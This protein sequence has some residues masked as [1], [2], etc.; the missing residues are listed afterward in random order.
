MAWRA[1]TMPLAEWGPFQNAFEEIFVAMKGDPDM[2]LF[3]QS[4]PG[5]ELSTLFITGRHA[6]LVERLSP[7]G[8]ENSDKPNGH[9]ISLLVGS[10]DPAEKFGIELGLR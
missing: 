7:G 4:P 8:W 9:H 5:A 6:D 10:G 1:K 2:A 3:I